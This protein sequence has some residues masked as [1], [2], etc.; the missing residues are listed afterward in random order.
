MWKPIH[1]VPPNTRIEFMRWHRLTFAI[2]V[3]MTLGSFG[4]MLFY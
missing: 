2:A 4:M 1:L 3:I